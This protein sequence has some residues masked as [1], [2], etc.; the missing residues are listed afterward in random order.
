MKHLPHV[1]TTPDTAWR[2]RARRTALA[3]TAASALI[4]TVAALLLWSWRD[5]LPDRIASHQGL[6]GRVDQYQSL[7]GFVAT[8]LGIG[9][10]MTALFALLLWLRG[11]S[12][13]ARRLLGALAVWG[14]A[15]IG[16]TTVALLNGQRGSPEAVDTLGTGAPLVI[17]LVVALALGAMTWFLIPQDPPLDAT[18]PVPAG[19]PRTPLAG[20]ERA[21]WLRTVQA[22]QMVVVAAVAI[23]ATGVPAVVGRLWWMLAIPVVLAALL[24]T[25]FRFVVRVDATGITVRSAAGWPRTH[26][27]AREVEE[28]RTVQVDP[29]R[30]FGGWGWRLRFDGAT[31]IVPRG[32]EG[33][34]VTRSGGRVLVV[35]VDDAADGAMLLNTMADRARHRTDHGSTGSARV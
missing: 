31:G 13:S 14:G 21:V 12:A 3:T 28:A 20:D 29:F 35:T 17:G 11:R 33:I 24:T 26:V 19:A 18:G 34:E 7:G 8:M 6:D 15:F 32:G 27:P 1:P 10:G 30:Q 2:R 16:G 23:L 9:L 5:S 4:L 22:P 25:M